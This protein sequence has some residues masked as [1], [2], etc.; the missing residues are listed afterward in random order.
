[1][2]NSKISDWLDKKISDVISP[3]EYELY[4]KNIYYY[5]KEKDKNIDLNNE[6]K[7]K[8]LK[9]F[10]DLL[11]ENNGEISYDTISDKIYFKKMILESRLVQSYYINN[12]KKVSIFLNPNSRRYHA[13]MLFNQILDYCDYH[14]LVDDNGNLIFNKYM[15]NEFYKFCYENSTKYY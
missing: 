2:S 1:M 4:N 3:P 7:I 12:K 13:N 10:E 5:Y 8:E 9:E 11:F 15:R 14:N 6:D